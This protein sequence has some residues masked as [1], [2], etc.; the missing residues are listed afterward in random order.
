ML[1]SLALSFARQGNGQRATSWVTVARTLAPPLVTSLTCAFFHAL[2]LETLILLYQLG[3]DVRRRL[4]ATLS[5]C[6]KNTN[7][8][9][10]L[11]PRVYT[12]LAFVKLL[13]GKTRDAHTAIA[14]AMHF[15][16]LYQQN[17]DI[18][19]IKH[20]KRAW[21]T[22]KKPKN[23]LNRVLL[24]GKRVLTS[25]KIHSTLLEE[26]GEE[27]GLEG[28]VYT[29]PLLLNEAIRPGDSAHC[30][31]TS[32]SAMDTKSKEEFTDIEKAGVAMVTITECDEQI[33]PETDSSVNLIIQSCA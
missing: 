21:F 13:R 11:R 22:D 7:V 5:L 14:R 31:K 10:C 23:L 17:L 4:R 33:V 20:C 30:T 12:Y 9:N 32:N 28:E 8:Y 1:I 15:A 25:K 6:L 24:P 18:I 26:E 29:L 2:L 27:A 16:Q 3:Y 19:R